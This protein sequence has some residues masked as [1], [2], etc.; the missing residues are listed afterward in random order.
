[1]NDLVKIHSYYIYS[2]AAFTKVELQPSI[3]RRKVRGMEHG[4]NGVDV[5]DGTSMGKKEEKN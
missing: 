4:Y 2:L 1:M 3:V 5:V